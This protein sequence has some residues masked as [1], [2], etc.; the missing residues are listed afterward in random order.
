MILKDISIRVKDTEIKYDFM[1]S[2][3]NYDCA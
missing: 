3:N 1:R 2:K